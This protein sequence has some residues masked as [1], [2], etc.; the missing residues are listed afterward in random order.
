MKRL[1]TKHNS[2][3]GKPRGSTASPQYLWDIVCFLNAYQK[4]LVEP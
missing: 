2:E 4:P 1:V 3:Q